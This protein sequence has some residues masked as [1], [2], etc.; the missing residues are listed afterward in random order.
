MATGLVASAE[1]ALGF[2]AKARTVDGKGVTIPSQIRYVHYAQ[3]LIAN[4]FQISEKTVYLE[5][6]IIH[7]IPKF[8]V[9]GKCNPF[10]RVTAAHSPIFT[11]SSKSSKASNV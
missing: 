2:Y 4:H 5:K 6:L 7:T 1:E 11:S 3:Y 9:D 8:G 10:F